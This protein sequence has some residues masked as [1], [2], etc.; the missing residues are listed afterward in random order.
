[1]NYALALE[2]GR[3][4]TQ[5][6]WSEGTSPGVKKIHA[7]IVPAPFKL[8]FDKRFD[9]PYYYA[10]LASIF[11]AALFLAGL[12]AF[13]EPNVHL[14]DGYLMIGSHL[15]FV[16]SIIICVSVLA[17]AYLRGEARKVWGYRERWL[18]VNAP[19]VIPLVDTPPPAEGESASYA[20]ELECEK[21]KGFYDE[22]KI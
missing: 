16:G 6:R 13:F 14:I 20:S 3:T 1:M 21:V 18:D 12:A 17:L 2:S 9:K 19:E 7:I 22:V 11:S 15:N 4:K 10:S 8:N 5:F